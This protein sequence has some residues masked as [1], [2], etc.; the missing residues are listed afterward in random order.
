MAPVRLSNCELATA[1]VVGAVATFTA[2]LPAFGAGTTVV[3]ALPPR[4]TATL[5]PI[6]ATAA[7]VDDDDAAAV[8][9][10]PGL[11]LATRGLFEGA[12]AA[13]EAALDGLLDRSWDDDDEADTGDAFGVLGLLDRAL[14]EAAAD[15]AG[16]TVKVEVLDLAIG[17]AGS[18]TIGLALN[19]GLDAD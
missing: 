13:A 8:D 3:L 4:G 11:L 17:L 2:P 14:S 6:A 1:L 15:T 5:P 7:A 16:G 19:A 18:G 9:G 12:A 10:L